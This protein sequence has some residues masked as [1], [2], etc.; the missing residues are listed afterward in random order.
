MFSTKHSRTH[1][2]QLF[3][4]WLLSF[5]ILVSEKNWEIHFNGDC[6]VRINVV[7]WTKYFTFIKHQK[8]IYNLFPLKCKLHL[9][10]RQDCTIFTNSGKN[11]RNRF[12][13]FWER[14]QVQNPSL[15]G[16]THDTRLHNC[17]YSICVLKSHCFLA[18]CVFAVEEEQLLSELDELSWLKRRKKR[19]VSLWSHPSLRW[20]INFSSPSFVFTMMPLCLCTHSQSCGDAT[21]PN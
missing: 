16:L 13:N 5:N 21:A 20:C 4:Q 10:L 12:W 17:K 15:L 9:F 14:F 6:S 11:K 8:F 7:K 1:V 19:A 18:L 2:F 3:F